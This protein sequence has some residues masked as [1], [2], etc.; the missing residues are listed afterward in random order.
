MAKCPKC[1]K[2][3]TILNFR[4]ECPKCGVNIP[5]YDWERRL[6]EDADKAEMAFAR[7]HYKTANFKS[8]T[9]GSPLRIVR[10]VCTFLP[11]IALVLPLAKYTIELPFVS[12][13]GS[14]TF[15]KVALKVFGDTGLIG[16][17]IN[18][19]KGELLG[20]LSTD[21]LI[22]VAGMFLAVVFGVLNFFVL[23][24]AAF[25]LHWRFNV[26]LNALAAA[27]FGVGFYYLKSFFELNSGTSFTVFSGSMS[28][29]FFVGIALFLLNMT[30]NIIVGI[31]FKKQKKSQPTIDEAAAVEIE[32]LHT[33]GYGYK[34]DKP[35]KKKKEKKAKK[36]AENEVK[37]DSEEE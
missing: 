23:L 29:A 19:T 2:E 36:E 34:D 25:N 1:G 20:Q 11:L 28:F 21:L 4:A 7:L 17:M 27:S 5:N 6:E 9:V 33:L 22:S 31:G 37:K 8:A 24:I 3:L 10:L 32:K 14:L 15:L 18:L 35:E 16:H 12:K 30:L 26:I 13:E